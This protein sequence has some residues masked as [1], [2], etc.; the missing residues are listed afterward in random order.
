MPI[1]AQQFP[2]YQPA[3][4]I[5][6]YLNSFNDLTRVV[7]TFPHQYETGLIV[8]LNLPPGYMP[9]GLNQQVGTIVEIID[10]TSFRVNIDS[11]QMENWFIPVEFPQ[12]QQSAQVTPVGEVSSDTY[13][14]T[15]N[16]LPY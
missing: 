7:T 13:L 1:L 11:S 8:R 5:I 9:Q 12:N 10:A 15:K 2:V 16:V 3:M 14:A 6:G 4:R